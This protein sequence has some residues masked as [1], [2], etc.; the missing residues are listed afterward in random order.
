M[1]Q[2][3]IA[4]EFEI[5]FIRHSVFLVL[6]SVTDHYIRKPKLIFSLVRFRLECREMTSSPT[7]QHA[8]P[9]LLPYWST[10]SPYVVRERVSTMTS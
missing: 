8:L 1:C 9:M 3:R 2:W 10:I 5:H 4:A 6:L 7:N